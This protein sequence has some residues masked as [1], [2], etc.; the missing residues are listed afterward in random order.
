MGAGLHH[1][2]MNTPE[3]L[4]A[5]MHTSGHGTV[6]DR[7]ALKL[8]V[9]TPSPTPSTEISLS[10]QILRSTRGLFAFTVPTAAGSRE[11][12]RTV[13]LFRYGC[14]TLFPGGH[15]RPPFFYGEQV[16]WVNA[17]DLG[18]GSAER[19]RDPPHLIIWK[20]GGLGWPPSLCPTREG[21]CHLR[22]FGAL[23]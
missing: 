6:H 12:G 2:E 14:V 7:I 22:A 16:G 8:S 17:R 5:I 21:G 4:V 15:P 10:I 23:E 9:S 1:S 11:G 20:L 13:V 3:G 19:A 18:S